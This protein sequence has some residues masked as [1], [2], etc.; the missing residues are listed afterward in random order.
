MSCDKSGCVD[1]SGA[2][3]VC[4]FLCL[5]L[6]S[7]DPKQSIARTC[8]YDI[9]RMRALFCSLV[10]RLGNVQISHLAVGGIYVCT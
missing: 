6:Y 10:R 7:C 3:F 1:K 2:T 5:C 9:F 8:H 4:A